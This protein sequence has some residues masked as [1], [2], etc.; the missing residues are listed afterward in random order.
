MCACARIHART[1]HAST[2]RADFAPAH[3]ALL[4]RRRIAESIGI[5]YFDEANMSPFHVVRHHR[6]PELKKK[7]TSMY[8]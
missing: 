2:Q 7:V 8:L 5:N 3:T 4:G 6:P 1:K